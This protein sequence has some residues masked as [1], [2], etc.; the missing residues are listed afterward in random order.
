MASSAIPVVFPSVK[1]GDEFFGDGSM[2]QISPLSPAIHLGA[3]KILIIGLRSE[4]QLGVREP[5]QH[6]PSLG[7]ISGYILDTLF[8]NSLHADVERMD[9]INRTLTNNPTTE[10]P[11]SVIDHLII[12]PT[13][14]IAEIA[15]KHYKKLPG[16][17]RMALTFLGLNRGNSQ[18][19][20]SYLTFTGDFCQELIKLGYKDAMAK[21]DEVTVF[22]ESAP[23]MLNT[24]E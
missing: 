7:E 4:S 13:E 14:D 24:H 9:R 19:L 10:E 16:N 21:R 23:S 12:S 5:A 3:N 20:I 18:R 15:R 6:R 1:L 11:L 8:L 2:R 17:F 22:L